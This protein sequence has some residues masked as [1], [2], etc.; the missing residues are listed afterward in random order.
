MQGKIQKNLFQ[1]LSKINYSLSRLLKNIDKPNIL[2]FG[3]QL[4]SSTKYFLDLC[5]EKNGKLYSVD[6]DDCSKLFNSN[7]WKFIQ[8]R[9]DNFD[10]ISGKI[11][12]KLDDC[13]NGPGIKVFYPFF[14]KDKYDR[15]V[16]ICSKKNKCLNQFDEGYGE[17]IK[18]G[19][20][21][22]ILIY[23]NL[24]FNTK[25]FNKRII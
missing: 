21:D 11:P 13:F 25:I 19:I 10:Y 7:Y 17:K 4:G 23:L 20:F 16:L 22:K 12:K 8:S 15:L 1:D 6:I 3:V 24:F 18:F 2:E 9:D 5:K 14:A